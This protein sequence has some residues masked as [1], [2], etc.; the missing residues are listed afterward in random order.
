[1]SGRPRN[2]TGH[3]GTSGRSVFT[4]EGT[5]DPLRSHP[6]E[7]PTDRPAGRSDR[8]CGEWGGSFLLQCPPTPSPTRCHSDLVDGLGEGADRSC[9]RRHECPA[10]F[11]RLH[12]RWFPPGYR[13]GPTASLNL[14][15]GRRRR[16]RLDDRL[17]STTN[18]VTQIC[19]L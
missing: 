3:V 5:E 10:F 6:R 11:Q 14:Y 12:I 9:T 1:M 8:S 19:R 13:K 18:H 4:E 15:K 16:V 17:M 7:R 2:E